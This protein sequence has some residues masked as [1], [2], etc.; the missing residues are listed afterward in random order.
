M[1]ECDIEQRIRE[2]GGRMTKIRRAVLGVLRSADGP[3]SASG[4]RGAIAR[5][6][7]PSDRTTIYRELR[8]LTEAGVVGEVRIAGHP[9]R[10]E[11][12]LGH[13]HHLVCLGCDTVRTVSIGDRLSAVEKRLKTREGFSVTGHALEFYGYC[14]KCRERSSNV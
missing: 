13:R 2:L 6:G 4:L 9:P 12:V 5:S 3:V 1:E 8:F 7:V 10:Y 14:G 11:L